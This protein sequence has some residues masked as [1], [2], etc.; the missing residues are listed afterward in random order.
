MFK[1]SIQVSVLNLSS[2][3]VQFLLSLF[4]TTQFGLGTD[5]DLYNKSI[6]IP[7]YLIVLLT[8]CITY[9][10]IPLYSRINRFEK[11]ES[12]KIINEYFIVVLVIA[13]LFLFTADFVVFNFIDLF[14]DNVPY[15]HVMIIQHTF[16]LYSP[17]IVFSSLI[18]FLNTIY[19][20]NDKFNLPLLGKIINPLLILLFFYL[21]NKNS[22]NLAISYLVVFFIHFSLLFYHING[23]YFQFRLSIDINNLLKRNKSLIKLSFPIIF[24]ITVT[25]ILPVYDVYFLSYF[26]KGIVS[27]VLLS[28]KLIITISFIINSFFSVLFFTQIS[29]YAADKE[30][31]KLYNMLLIGIKSL[32]FISIPIIFFSLRN[33]EEIFKLIFVHGKF[34]LNDLN[35]LVKSFKI[36]LLGL[37]AIVI[38][39]LISYAL[40]S[41]QKLNMFI[42]TSIL[43]V[44]LYV[45][46]SIILK[47]KFGYN[48]VSLA[49]IINFAVSDLILFLL[50]KKELN[51]FV[52]IS[53]NF[54]DTLKLILG[55]SIFVFYFFIVYN[56]LI[57]DSILFLLFILFYLFI[58]IKLNFTPAT[59]LYSKIKHINE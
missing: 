17:I 7:S 45:S 52:N 56:N 33:S 48:S 14:I 11:K 37:P 8:S 44:L 59:Y 54:K 4:I 10:F 9:I 21:F 35:L 6:V 19:Y 22:I 13:V 57:F 27:N 43:E 32:I 38:G 1:K 28:Q 16:I 34:N 31:D 58:L 40:Y 50:L 23:K 47:S 29:K 2:F 26:S 36:F 49:F 53:Y 42:Y 39:S 41:M 51:K 25:K 46:I 3:V 55:S 18:E 20:S 24:S 15:N 12:P 5:L 30:Y